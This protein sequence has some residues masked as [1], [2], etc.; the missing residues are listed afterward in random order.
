MTPV[1][2]KNFWSKVNKHSGVFAVIDGRRSECWVWTG[3]RPNGEY[4]QIGLAI[5]NRSAH[6]MS[7]QLVN[8]PV[9]KG[10][11]VLHKCDN[12]PCVRP[13]HL[14]LGTH[15][16]NMDDMKAKGRQAKG[17]RSGLRVH[18]ERAATGNRHGSVTHPESRPRG[19]NHYARLAPDKLA[20]AERHGLVSLSQE[21]VDKIVRFAR[22][23]QI[24]QHKLGK[25]F[26]VSKATIGRI[27]RGEHWGI[28]NCA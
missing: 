9:S 10:K 28:S 19:N 11:F 14:F 27:L 23:K 17:D 12:R 4:G 18:P 6:R 15:Q 7:W 25:K 16:D 5:P 13:S 2:I 24:S 20:R 8:G 1:Q 22:I 21:D 26:K 3:C